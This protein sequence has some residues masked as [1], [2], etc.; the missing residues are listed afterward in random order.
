MDRLRVAVVGVGHLG[1]H[2]ARDPRRDRGGRAGRGRRLPDRA[3]P[4]RRRPVRGESGRRLPG[5]ARRWGDRRRLGGCTDFPPPRS[6]RSVPRTG[7]S[8]ARRESPSPPRRPRPKNSSG[9][10]NRW[11]PSSRSATSSGT[12][13]PSRR[14]ILSGSAAPLPLGRAALD[15][16]IPVY[17]HRRDLR[18][19]DPR[20]RRGPEPRPRAVHRRLGP[21]RLRLRRPRGYRQRPGSGSRAAPSPISPPAGASD[22]AVR[23]LKIWSRRGTRRSI[24]ARRAV[25]RSSVLRSYFGRASSN[26]KAST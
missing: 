12:T 20:Y 14:S 19:H 11:V 3:G 15:L 9:S 10:R 6:R 13:P 25:R 7:D 5:I 23:K 8:D 18:P 17:R 1:R 21:R 2:H 22:Q 4:G 24:S 26:W 16:H